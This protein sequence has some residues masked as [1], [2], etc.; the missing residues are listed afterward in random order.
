MMKVVLTCLIIAVVFL[1]YMLLHKPPDP[2]E[3]GREVKI[4][5]PTEAELKRAAIRA[6]NK[7]Y[8]DL[9]MERYNVLS[10]EA[11][12]NWLKN[13]NY[14]FQQ[15]SKYKYIIRRFQDNIEHRYE[16]D[17]SRLEI[18]HRFGPHN[19]LS[20]AMIIFDEND[21]FRIAFQGRQSINSN[22][23]QSINPNPNYPSTTGNPSGGGR[24]NIPKG[25]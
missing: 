1:L 6:V 20:D 18:P 2:P 5:R 19:I 10:P 22:W 11:S 8:I 14:E 9:L 12:I 17:V 3:F 21:R 13:N 24:G 23:S 15:T 4:I 25:K 7:G 16:I